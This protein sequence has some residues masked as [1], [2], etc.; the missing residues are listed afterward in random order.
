MWLGKLRYFNRESAKTR[1]PENS[2][3]VSNCLRQ[4][5]SIWRFAI[6][7]MRSPRI[8]KVLLRAFAL[9]RVRD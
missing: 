4:A 8:H 5:G 2:N 1:K 7:E 3:S 9:S 6:N